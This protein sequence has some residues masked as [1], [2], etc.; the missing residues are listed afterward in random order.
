MPFSLTVEEHVAT[1]E[2]DRDDK[3]NAMHNPMFE[4]LREKLAEIEDNPEVRVAVL[5]GKG[6][7]FCAGI[8]LMSLMGKM[9]VELGAAP[10]GAKQAKFHA[11][12][13]WLQEPLK[14]IERCRVPFIAAIHGPCLGLGVDLVT[15]CDIRLATKDAVLS[16][17][18][19]KMAIVAD[20]GSLQRLP[21]IVGRGRARELVFTGR[22]VSGQEA[23]EIGLVDEVLEDEA[24]L[25]A[26]AQEMAA[27]IAANPPLTVQGAKR[28]MNEAERAEIDRGLEFVATWNVGHLLTQDLGVAVTAFMT[29]QKPEFSGR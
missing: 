8:D 13:R 16:V 25:R 7:G 28:V 19:T 5:A 6:R 23:K 3:R 10:D 27:Q 11:F 17:R 22:D 9:P 20:L 15:A 4:S 29:K 26:R 21:L 14:H 12:I 1:L 24:S 18:E 2:L